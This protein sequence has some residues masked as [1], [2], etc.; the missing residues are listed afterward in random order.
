MIVVLNEDRVLAEIMELTQIKI[1]M[2]LKVPR[3]AVTAKWRR[4]GATGLSPEL[5]VMEDAAEGVS[6]EDITAVIKN[7]WRGSKLIMNERLSGL[8]ERRGY[9]EEKDG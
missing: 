2:I 1:A 8:K 5:G 6:R 9:E 3:E 4:V 7:V